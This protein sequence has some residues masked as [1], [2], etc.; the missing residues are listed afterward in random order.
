MSVICLRRYSNN[1]KPW[2]NQTEIVGIIC[3]HIG[4]KGFSL[5]SFEVHSLKTLITDFNK[6]SVTIVAGFSAEKIFL[7]AE[8]YAITSVGLYKAK[9]CQ[10]PPHEDCKF[11]KTCYEPS[12]HTKFGQFDWDV[13]ILDKRNDTVIENPYNFLTECFFHALL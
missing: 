10:H 5:S 11:D 6:L 13:S 1:F 4:N 12:N 3:S 8:C 9:S 7:W 2:G